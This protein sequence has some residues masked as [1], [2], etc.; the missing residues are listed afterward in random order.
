[1]SYNDVLQYVVIPSS[2]WFQF[3]L[4]A[5]FEGR[6]IIHDREQYAK[7]GAVSLYD[8]N[9]L[10]TKREVSE[11]Q[12]K[13]F[14]KELPKRDVTLV[15]QISR[16][17]GSYIIANESL[18]DD[19]I[20]VLQSFLEN[21]GPIWD[22]FILEVFSFF[23]NLSFGNSLTIR[24]Y[25]SWGY[26]VVNAYLR[27]RFDDDAFQQE[28]YERLQAWLRRFAMHKEEYESGSISFKQLWEW[29]EG[30]P[31]VLASQY[32]ETELLP[33]QL[34]LL[35]EDPD[36]LFDLIT[37]TK[38]KQFANDLDRI[39]ESAPKLPKDLLVF[40]GT[41][42][43][44]KGKLKGF[45]S[46]STALR[47]AFQ[48]AEYKACCYEVYQLPK[49]MPCFFLFMEEEILLPSFASRKAW[50]SEADFRERIA[51]KMNET[52]FYMNALYGEPTQDIEGI[53][54]YKIE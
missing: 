3:L 25:Q 28:I 53:K 19:E 38:A 36:A 43:P 6:S 32:G 37:K 48:F 40:R 7:G 14:R 52:L 50:K 2:V 8:T 44:I 22:K 30:S 1:M 21:E 20:R 27:K 5:P 26:K 31:F 12:A 46:T 10:Q 33:F 11:F 13:F 45:T 54:F 9:L 16:R 4:E 34:G 47:Y 15:A 17:N 41:T 51:T 42:S 35:D 39:I 18:N 23:S 24:Q 49:G 29:F